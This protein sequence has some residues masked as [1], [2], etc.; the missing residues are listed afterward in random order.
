MSRVNLMIC[1]TCSFFNSERLLCSRMEKFGSILGMSYLSYHID[2]GASIPERCPYILE[3]TV[4]G[5]D[6]D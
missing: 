1:A 2:A 3:H 4:T 6:E 5:D